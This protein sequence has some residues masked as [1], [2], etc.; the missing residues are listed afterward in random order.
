MSD[1]TTLEREAVIARFWEHYIEIPQ[2]QH[3][4][5]PFDRW[6]VLWAQGYIDACPGF[7]LKERQTSDLTK[8]FNQHLAHTEK[9]L[10]A[11]RP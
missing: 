9:S 2:K 6:Y 4:T 10:I 8:Y 3:I 5:K 11:I 1:R 7:C